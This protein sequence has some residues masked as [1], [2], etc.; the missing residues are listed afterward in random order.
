MTLVDYSHDEDYAFY[1]CTPLKCE[2]LVRVP[3]LVS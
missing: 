2:D 3:S 1:H